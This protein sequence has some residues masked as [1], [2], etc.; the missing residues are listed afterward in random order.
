[1]PRVLGETNLRFQS[2]LCGIKAIRSLDCTLNSFRNFLTSLRDQLLVRRWKNSGC[3]LHQVGEFIADRSSHG[4]VI[5]YCCLVLLNWFF[6]PINQVEF[7]ADPCSWKD[8]QSHS[9]CSCWT[10]A[11]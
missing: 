5:P 3:G 4:S 1:M 7:P 6:I 9:C 10:R 2:V 8:S 11:T